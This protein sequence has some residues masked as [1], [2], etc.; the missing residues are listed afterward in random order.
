MSHSS[1]LRA[2]LL[3]AV[4]A[5]AA[6]SQSVTGSDA[7]APP[8]V[9]VDAS[10]P[11]ASAPDVVSDV[12][13]DTG[14]DAPLCS[15]GTPRRECLTMAQAEAR[16]RNPVG[17]MPMRD[18]GSDDVPLDVPVAS[19]GCY[20][21]SALTDDCCNR[22][23][24]VEREG[25]TCCYTF[26]T[27][28][29]CGRPFAIDGGARVAALCESDA[30]CSRGELASLDA[31]TRDALA[32]AWRRDALMEHASIASFARFTLHM[33]A[34]GAPPALVADAQRA[35]LDEV[36]HARSCFD[37]AARIDGGVLGPGAL[38][39]KGALGAMSVAE[40]VRAAV[41]EGCV[42]ETCAALVARSRRDAARDD[43]VRDA[44]GRI[45]SDESEHAALAWRFVAWAIATGGEEARESAGR[46]FREAR[47]I[48]APGELRD[49]VDEV[50]WSAYGML[51]PR[52][53]H[54]VM[55]AAIDEVVTPCARALLASAVRS[56]RAV[57][58][59]S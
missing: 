24:L 37:I 50:A 8:D 46:A 13:R 48:A 54:A 53:E 36:D 38:D 2:F 32:A 17:E 27:G 45:A 6:C 21:A 25:D 41:L 16:I 47:S 49:G 51:T 4:P 20:A 9:V 12:G 22:A 43:A 55:R 1:E 26:C 33:M 58:V 18:A 23:V 59:V 56:E 28:A 35:A 34:L 40:A 52:E 29:C 44:L 42:G 5:L 7:A 15:F 3:A 10:A 57:T 19:N 11:D 39:V 14:A 30:W 31:V